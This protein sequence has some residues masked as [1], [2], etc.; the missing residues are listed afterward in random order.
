MKGHSKTGGAHKSGNDR[1]D[2]LAVAAK[3]EASGERRSGRRP[4]TSAF[5]T[6]AERSVA[7]LLGVERGLGDFS[8]L[9]RGVS[10]ALPPRVT[11]LPLNLPIGSITASASTIYRLPKPLY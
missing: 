7:S 5:L 8:T 9:V 1:A 4:A 2:E 11:L 10:G 6:E 3:K